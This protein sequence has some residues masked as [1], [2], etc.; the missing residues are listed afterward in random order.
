MVEVGADA[1]HQLGGLP[2]TAKVGVEVGG[3][4]RGLVAVGILAYNASNVALLAACH[5]GT[6]VEEAVEE[7][8]GALVAAEH[9]NPFVDIVWHVG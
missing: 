1:A 3:V 2:L 5:H 7:L 8:L 4:V 9:T 6:A